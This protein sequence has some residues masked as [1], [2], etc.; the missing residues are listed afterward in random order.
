MEGSTINH[1]PSII[2]H[3]PSIINHQPSIINHQPSIINHQ[4]STINHQSSIINH[5]SSTINH[6]P[7]IINHQSSTI[8]HQPSTFNHQSSTICKKASLIFSILLASYRLIICGLLCNHSLF[9]AHHIN[10]LAQTFKC[11]IWAYLSLQQLSVHI[12]DIDW[13]ICVFFN[14]L[15][16]RC[17]WLYFYTQT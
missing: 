7:S 8:N 10:T 1:Q 17:Q 11:F 6:Q 15:F 3:Q 2:N 5:Q 14:N 12:V 16:Y 13:G 4:S 9:I